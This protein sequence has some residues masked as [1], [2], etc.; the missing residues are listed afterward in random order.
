MRSAP[1]IAAILMAAL[2]AT[3]CEPLY[4]L[5]E[6]G[7][8]A[9][10]GSSTS[11][12]AKPGGGPP[13]VYTGNYASTVKSMLGGVTGW[14]TSTNP[15]TDPGVPPNVKVGTCTRDLYVAAAVNYAWA[16]ESYFR[17]GDLTQSSK[18]AGFMN[19]ELS[20]ATSLCSGNPTAVNIGCLT[21][22]IWKCP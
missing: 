17:L 7:T 13:A 1:C 22:P 16:A 10:G 6:P 9:E 2:V 12:S 15:A 18:M 5:T 4:E 19:G 3:A 8:S 11:G 14:K 20:K 21:M